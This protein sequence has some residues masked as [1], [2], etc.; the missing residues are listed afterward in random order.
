MDPFHAWRIK[1]V[2]TAT[3]FVQGGEL[4]IISEMCVYQQHQRYKYSIVADVRSV[5]QT[6]N[7]INTQL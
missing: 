5:Y 4:G 7:A 1:H 3:I 6:T 2:V